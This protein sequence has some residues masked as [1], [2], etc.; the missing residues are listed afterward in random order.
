MSF[1]F[2]GK[3]LH[4]SDIFCLHA[5]TKSFT[6]KCH[7]SVKYTRFKFSG[8]VDN[9]FSLPWKDMVELSKIPQD[10][11]FKPKWPT[12]C[13]FPDTASE[14]IFYSGCTKFHTAE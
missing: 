3:S 9:M 10:G 12:S 14:D 13:V 11:R 7:T 5:V 2:Y 6:I 1:V 8:Q 4:V